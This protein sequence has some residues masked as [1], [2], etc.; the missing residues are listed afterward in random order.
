M[1]IPNEQKILHYI[2]VESDRALSY[3]NR[4]DQNKYFASLRPALPLKPIKMTLQ[5]TVFL[6]KRE[7]GEES[8]EHGDRTGGHANDGDARESFAAQRYF[9]IKRAIIRKDTN[10]Q[11]DTISMRLRH[12]NLLTTYKTFR[13]EFVDRNNERQDIVWLYSQFLK[14][15]IS[16]KY[17]AMDENIIRHILTDV[18]HGLR[19]MHERKIMHLDIKIANIMGQTENNRIV[20]K[21]IDFGYARDLTLTDKGNKLEEIKIPSKSYGTFPYKPPEVVFEN[22]HGLKSDIWCVGAV[23][24]FLSLGR[25]PFYH[26]NGEKNTVTYRRFIKG[27]KKH[28]FYPETSN[29]LR[30]F[31]L[32][33]MNRRRANRPSVKELL[34]HPF[35]LGTKFEES[36]SEH[37]SGFGSDSGVE[38]YKDNNL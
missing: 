13:T 10:T 35:I 29:E 14:H 31:V 26:D 18:L 22:V 2:D 19:Y 11:E 25:V 5:T 28:F 6:Y 9:V 1:S 24:W 36:E 34:K 21:L 7:G 37:D 20:Y 3:E 8:S 23:A 4:T 15:R 38:S 16:H 12:P 32:V 30:D 17:V 27:T 33:S